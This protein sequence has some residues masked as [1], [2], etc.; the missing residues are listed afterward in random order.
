[1][2]TNCHIHTYP[3]SHG[4]NVETHGRIIEPSAY[5]RNYHD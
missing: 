1:M 3:A 5:F 2:K 4:A